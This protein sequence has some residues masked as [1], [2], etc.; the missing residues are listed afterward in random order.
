MHLDLLWRDEIP[1]DWKGLPGKD[2]RVACEV[3]VTFGDP[4]ATTSLSEQSVLVRGY[5]AVVVNNKLKNEAALNAIPP[6]QR[7]IAAALAGQDPANAPYGI[8]RFDWDPKTRTCGSTWANRDLSIPNGI[9]SMSTATGL[10]YGIGQ[11]GGTW[12]LEGIDFATGRSVLRVD[13]T[14]TPDQNSVYAATTVGPDGTVWTGTFL[15]YTI[16]RGP[17]KA[18]PALG[19][20]DLEAPSSRVRTARSRTLTRSRITARRLVVA[21]PVRDRAC[22]NVVRR[23]V[24]RVEVS[25]ARR[26]KG[27]CRHLSG[28]RLGRVRVV[29]CARLD[30][31]VRVEGPPAL[32][33]APGR[34]ARGRPVRRRVAGAGRPGEHRVRR[35]GSSR[36]GS[37][38]GPSGEVAVRGPGAGAHGVLRRRRGSERPEPHGSRR[39]RCPSPAAIRPRSTSPFPMRRRSTTARATPS[40]P[41]RRCGS[42]AGCRMRGTSPSTPTIR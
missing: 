21:G 27:G 16:F 42:P 28:T 23:N 18:G 31:S 39:A 36:C 13:T 5:G 19:C 34:A 6:N 32:R 26:V 1:A 20:A 38:P 25:V 29:R 37:R 22:G 12:G 24:A 17:V 40:R 4:G 3:P 9:P 2:R 35:V 10:I 7:F 15:G 11:R 33:A 14:P 30:A 41:E 8:E